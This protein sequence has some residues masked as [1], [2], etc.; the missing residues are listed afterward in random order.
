MQRRG[1]DWRPCEVRGGGHTSG[2]SAS[3][4]MRAPTG[5]AHRIPSRSMETE[6][7]FPTLYAMVSTASSRV[8]TS[9]LSFF[10]SL[11]VKLAVTSAKYLRYKLIN[12][13]RTC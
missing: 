2:A 13:D 3:L 12:R 1:G 7:S 4:A 6:P 11:L 9:F 5:G 8:W 10:P